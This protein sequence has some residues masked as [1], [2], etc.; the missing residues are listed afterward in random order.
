MGCHFLLQGVFLTKGLNLSVL[1]WQS[2]SLPLSHQGSFADNIVVVQ[3]PSR[4]PMDCST[5]GLPVPHHL[6]KFAQVHVHCTGDAF[7]RSHLPLTYIHS[8]ISKKSIDKEQC[9]VYHRKY[10]SPL[11]YPSRAEHPQKTRYSFMY[12][13]I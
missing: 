10:Y 7:Q 9:M 12:I 11:S 6:L 1:H 5:P 4:D 2:D 13:C 3:S 8:N